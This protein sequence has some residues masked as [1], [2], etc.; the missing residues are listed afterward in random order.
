MYLRVFKINTRLQL[1][2]F[3]ISSTIYSLNINCLIGTSFCNFPIN[4]RYYNVIRSSGYRVHTIDYISEKLL[5]SKY[6]A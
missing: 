2:L 6:L 1:R 4:H 5:G 3:R